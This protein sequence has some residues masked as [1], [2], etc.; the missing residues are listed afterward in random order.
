MAKRN[1]YHGWA[2]GSPERVAKAKSGLPDPRNTS[3]SPGSFTY[4]P[5]PPAQTFDAD[6]ERTKTDL[7][8]NRDNA[9][10]QATYGEGRA[11]SDFGFQ[12]NRDPSTG[13][14]TAGG[15]DLSNPFS[16][17]SLLQRSYETSKRS[18]SNQYAAMGQGFSGAFGAQ[19]RENTHGY[20]QDYNALTQQF[21]DL[22]AGFT[23][24]RV[25][26]QSAY[27]SGVADADLAKLMRLLQGG[28]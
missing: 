27:T 14:A 19:Q 5:Q 12:L 2:A 16:K 6:F 1:T 26:A 13:F 17:M 28:A 3:T 18:T 21:A 22:L 7:G 4:R 11:A 25:N 20:Q 9:L 10:A 24:D 8:A 23:Q 15:L